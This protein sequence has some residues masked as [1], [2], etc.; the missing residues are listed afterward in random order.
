[1]LNKQFKRQ[2]FIS[3]FILVLMFILS[4]YDYLVHEHHHAFSFENLPFF[5]GLIGIIGALFITVVVKIL[6]KIV[7]RGE[8]SYER[9]YTS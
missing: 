4:L 1:M 3:S 2:I 6:G 5:T 7:S 8:D 9:Y